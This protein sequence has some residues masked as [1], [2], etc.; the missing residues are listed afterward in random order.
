MWAVSVVTV[1]SF[2]YSA[3]DSLFDSAWE[4]FVFSIDTSEKVSYSEC[5]WVPIGKD[6]ESAWMD[7]TLRHIEDCILHRTARDRITTLTV[8]LRPLHLRQTA[9]L[10]L[11]YSQHKRQLLMCSADAKKPWFDI[12]ICRAFIAFGC[13]ISFALA[14]K[15]HERTSRMNSQETPWRIMPA[16]WPDGARATRWIVAT[17]IQGARLFTRFCT[18]KSFE[19][20]EGSLGWESFK[21]CKNGPRSPNKCTNV[22]CHDFHTWWMASGLPSCSVLSVATAIATR[23]MSAFSSTKS[24]LFQRHAALLVTN[25][26]LCLMSGRVSGIWG[27]TYF[28]T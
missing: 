1:I 12:T 13:E 20:L 22:T 10:C 27:G 15:W 24:I 4:C 28:S 2:E 19:H 25:N 3:L 16:R 17:Y 7:F 21:V 11:T 23:G 26:A 9:P 8:Q 18:G 6:T 5:Y 14:S